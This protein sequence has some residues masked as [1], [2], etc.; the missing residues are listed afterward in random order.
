MAQCSGWTRR[1]RH[2]VEENRV[3]TILERD[4]RVLGFDLR[5][6]SLYHQERRRFFERWND[7]TA[8]LG[9]LLGSGTAIS[10]LQSSP[11]LAVSIA[12]AMTVVQALNLV[13]GF[14]RRAWMHGDLYRSFIDLEIDWVKSTASPETLADLTVCRRE[15]EKQEPA[16][17]PYLVRRCHIELMR[18]EGHPPDQWPPKLRAWQRAFAQFLPELR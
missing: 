15:V 11:R 3:E 17:M 4:W 9:V 5:L 6:C 2:P 18:R 10:L 14:S 12:F 7:L 16:P 1:H 13:I 8:F